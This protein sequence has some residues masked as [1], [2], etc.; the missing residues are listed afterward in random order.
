MDWIR[1]QNGT[2]NAI[3]FSEAAFQVIKAIEALTVLI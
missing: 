3:G 2:S 1:T